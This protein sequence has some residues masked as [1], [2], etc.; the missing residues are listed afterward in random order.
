MQSIDLRKLVSASE[1]D[2]QDNTDEIRKLKHSHLIA[3]DV[4]NIMAAMLA[5]HD[6]NLLFDSGNL[7]EC[8][9][10]QGRIPDEEV[11]ERCRVACP[12]LSTGYPDIFAKIFKKEINV[13]ILFQVLNV[14]SAIEDKEIDQAAGSVQVGKLLF[15]MFVDS[16]NREADN[17]DAIE[18]EAALEKESAELL[19]LTP[20]ERADKAGR[21]T[22]SWKSFKATM[23]K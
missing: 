18:R 13:A 4:N 3:D 1:K 9:V 6:H 19:H 14:L 7:P 17:T 16:R 20:E 8:A 12:L 22:L 21:K 2:Y 23:E 5:A 10:D 15:N 11:L